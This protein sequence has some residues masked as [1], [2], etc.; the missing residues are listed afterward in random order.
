MIR[1]FT[2]RFFRADYDYIYSLNVIIIADFKLI[3]I[4]RKEI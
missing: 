2:E 3:Q 1:P 4:F